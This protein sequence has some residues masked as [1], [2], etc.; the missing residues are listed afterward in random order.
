L[1]NSYIVL[2]DSP[3]KKGLIQIITKILLDFNCNIDKNNEFVDKDNK[4]FFMR[5]EIS[6]NSIDTI[7]LK[8]TLSLALPKKSN[9][10]IINKQKKKK[11]LIFTTKESH[12]LGDILLRQYENDLDIEILAVIS[13]RIST[14]D[15]TNK[16]NIDYLHIDTDNIS[17][18][19]HE[20]LMI[21][22][23]K[24]Y[25]FDYIVLAK[26]MR[27]LS[28][29]FVQ[30]FKHKIINIH[31]SFLPAFIGANPYEK[32]YARG[33]KIIGATAHFVTKDLD[34]GP[35][36][37]QDIQHVNHNHTLEEMKKSGKT[38]EKNTLI[39]ALKLII[40]DKVF[41]INNKTIIF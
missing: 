24:L 1:L 37:A 36:I 28:N 20:A 9:I 15:L 23:I 39:Q 12:V 17:R 3:D 6:G 10:S 30:Q 8:E 26:Y 32:A 21:D 34:E 38:I 13:N 27:I 33:V 29:N 41:I 11:I 5:S 19:E 22:K 31:H 14:K 25:D 7:L 18:D 16:F 40:E 2:I 4:I 35:I